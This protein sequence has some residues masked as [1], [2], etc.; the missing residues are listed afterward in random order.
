MQVFVD[1]AG[2]AFAYPL[3]RLAGVKVACYTHYPIISTDM[4]LRVAQRKRMYNNEGFSSTR[5]GAVLKLVYYYTFA[6]L[7][8]VAG[9]CANVG[10]QLKCL[11]RLAV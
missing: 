7:Y 3:V 9:G 5:L 10:S 8:G 6:S 11:C 2:W 4:L 1:T